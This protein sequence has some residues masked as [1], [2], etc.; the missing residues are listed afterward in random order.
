MF[1]TQVVKSRVTLPLDGAQLAELDELELLPE[2][3]PASP[4]V[5]TS[6]IAATAVSFSAMV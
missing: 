1:G 4:S 5:A 6:A 3:Q 2:E